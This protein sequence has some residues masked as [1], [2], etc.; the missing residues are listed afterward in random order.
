VVWIDS[1]DRGVGGGTSPGVFSVWSG[2]ARSI[3]AVGALRP[4]QAVYRDGQPG[5][6]L[7]GVYASAGVMK[8]LGVPPVLGRAIDATDDRAG[9]PPVL[10]ISDRLWR[11]Q[12]AGSPDILGRAITLAG[13]TR[14]IIGVMSPALDRLSFGYDWWAPLAL[15][16]AQSANVGPRYLEVIGRLRDAGPRTVEAELSSLS[17]DAGAVGDTGVPLGV[18]VEPL[19]EHFSSDAR[20][21]LLPLLG[22]VLAVV[23]LAALNAASLLLA[24][25]QSRHAEIAL[26]ASLG[27][28]RTRLARQ[29]LFESAWLTAAA[30]AVSLLLSLWLI[31]FL[32]T[33]PYDEVSL[34]NVALDWRAGL[35]TLALVAAV[36]SL[37][38]LLP[39]V[40][41]SA[42]DLRDSLSSGGRAIVSGPDRLRRA[43][44]I[45]QVALAL[46]IGTAGALMAR[47]MLELTSAPRGYDGD[48][49]LTAAIQ[50]P[51]S[52]YPSTAQLRAAI[53]RVAASVQLIP[54][55][56]NA[57]IAT[58]VPLSGGAPGSDLALVSDAFKPG[59]DRQVRIRFITPGYFPS[60]GTPLVEGRDVAAS[61]VETSAPVVLVNETLARR[62]GGTS[63]LV[64]RS[65]KFEVADFNSRGADTPWAIVGVVADARDGGPRA[66]VQPEVYVPMAQGPGDVFDWIGRQVLI[67]ARAG[68][69]RPVEAFG[70]ARSHRRR[71]ARPCAV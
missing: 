65:V 8:V 17:R 68:D 23:L 41:N 3:E 27:A 53:S 15:S 26:R 49:V 59:T 46:T 13:K 54:G 6:R 60:V 16:A 28:S 21:V 34:A 55:V 51:S 40:R 22:A 9:A 70:P 4:S 12:Y 56:K 19:K 32:K 31:D 62:L 71:R 1:L 58:R 50:F 24:Q 33:M 47:T 11:S 18:R 63:A 43:L 36:T 2:R 52:E 14:T 29:L 20:Q 35:F 39:A 44:V 66:S 10:M 61:D 45:L 7:A 38:G 67:A 5:Q 25:G 37:C 48:R 69:G 30:G 64:G 42:V 57:A